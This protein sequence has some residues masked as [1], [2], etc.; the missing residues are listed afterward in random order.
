MRRHWMYLKYVVR[1]KWYVMLE[2]WRYGLYW[3]GLIHDWTKLLPR[4]WL[5]YA[6]SFRNPDGSMRKLETLSSDE[7]IQFKRV[8]RGHINR[9]PHHW[10]WWIRIEGDGNIEALPME[11]RYCKEMLADWRGASRAITDFDDTPKWYSK[12][13]DDMVLHADTRAWIEMELGLK[14]ATQ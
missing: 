12:N 3:Q 13:R 8:L 5:P 14:E 9:H 6:R 1:H 4:E 2:C 7:Q 10:A 11:E